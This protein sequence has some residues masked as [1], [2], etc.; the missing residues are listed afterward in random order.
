MMFAVAVGDTASQVA[1][2]MQEVGKSPRPIQSDL[3]AVS[4]SLTHLFLVLLVI[5]TSWVGW[6]HSSATRRYMGALKEML[7]PF[8]WLISFPFTMLLIDVFLVVC[9]FVLSEGAELPVYDVQTKQ[10]TLAP[11]VHSEVV[12]QLARTFHGATRSHGRA[13]VE[14]PTASGRKDLFPGGSPNS[15][16]K[17]RRSIFILG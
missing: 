6:A 5:A 14:A 8:P 15:E 10:L 3:S 13:G 16:A 2:V 17:A 1:K 9:Y 12:V 4:P 7:S 11:S